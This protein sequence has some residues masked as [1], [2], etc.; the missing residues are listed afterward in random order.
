MIILWHVVSVIRSSKIEATSLS[1]T[2]SIQVKSHTNVGIQGATECSVPSGT[3]MIIREDIQEKEDMLAK[4]MAVR[5]NIIGDISSSS[6]KIHTIP[7]QLDKKWRL[8]LLQQHLALLKVILPLSKKYG[9]KI[10]RRHNLFWLIKSFNRILL[11]SKWISRKLIN[12][13]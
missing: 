9:I 8:W 3:E 7:S 11:V 2:E 10:K 5:R 4:N 6:M 13:A 1:T 12:S